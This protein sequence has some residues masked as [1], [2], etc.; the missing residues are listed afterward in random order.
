MSTQ[1]TLEAKST[2]KSLIWALSADQKPE[3]YFSAHPIGQETT[4]IQ[5]QPVP[6][7]S[8]QKQSDDWSLNKPSRHTRLLASC[9]PQE[10]RIKIWSFDIASA[11]AA[12]TPTAPVHDISLGN[13]SISHMSF[14]PDGEYIVAAAYKTLLVFRVAAG[15]LAYAYDAKPDN[16]PKLV[17]GPPN[18]LEPVPL[19]HTNGDIEMGGMGDSDSGTGELEEHEV[20]S[21][22]WERSG[23]KLAVAITGIGVS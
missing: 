17:E 13:L 14:S 7:D 1:K 20:T 22:S 3:H 4:F 11:T 6:Q 12:T 23:R 15:H 5:W 8:S 2:E 21:L 10:R 16:S 18:G 9:N 19:K